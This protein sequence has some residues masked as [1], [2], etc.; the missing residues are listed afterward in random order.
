MRLTTQAFGIE[1]QNPVMLAAGT[2][3]FGLE[4]VDVLDIEALGGFVTK[5]ITLEPRSGN[6]APRVTEFDSGMMNSVGLAN[7]GMVRARNEKL[8]WIAANIRRA[9]VLVSVA[10]HTVDEYFQLIE[11]LDPSD[12][13]AGFEINLSCPNDARRDGIPFALDPDAVTEIMSGCRARTERP[14]SAKLAPNDPSLGMTV[15]RAEEA[16]ADAITLVNTLPGLLLD[17]DSGEPRLGQGAGGVSGPALRPAGIRAVREARA[18]T[19]LPLL[20]VG[21]V[22]APEDAVAYGR[23][24]ASLVQMGTATFAAPR[25]ATDLISGLE[26]WGRRHGVEAWDDLRERTGEEAG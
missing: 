11:G 9:R 10:G 14:I 2:C 17:A 23:A 16:G 13:F 8:P 24:G 1:F 19:A 21:G 5:S 25:A 26:R 15:R 7:P 6:P 12:G 3:G 4:L 22:F 20:G 18:S